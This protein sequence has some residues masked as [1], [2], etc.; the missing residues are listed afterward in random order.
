MKFMPTVRATKV[1]KAEPAVGPSESDGGE[2][3]RGRGRGRGERGRGRGRGRG[4]FGKQELTASGPFALGPA[5]R[6]NVRSGGGGFAPT[7]RAA[8]GGPGSGSAS[9]GGFSGSRVGGGGS[10]RASKVKSEGDGSGD[11]G[12]DAAFSDS[13]DDSEEADNANWGQG[14]SPLQMRPQP[15][16]KVKE[17][18]RRE[19]VKKERREREEKKVQ[20]K[21][22]PMEEDGDG[23]GSTPQTVSSS[24]PTLMELDE[25]VPASGITGE[26]GSGIQ[27]PGLE[28][29]AFERISSEKP[30]NPPL[31]FFQLPKLLPR[32]DPNAMDITPVSSS[33][34][35]SMKTE[36]DIKAD[37]SK[38]QPSSGAGSAKAA[39]PTILSQS[40]R[41]GTLRVHRS[42]RVTMDLGGAPFVVY[43]GSR[44]GF[45][46]QVSLIQVMDDHKGKVKQEVPRGWEKPGEGA[47]R[48]KL[49]VVGEV[50]S[51]GGRFVVAAAV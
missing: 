20:I 48:A 42:G 3:G 41:I 6:P 12:K 13:D 40:G 16:G 44:V 23:R 34:S 36:V 29:A 49:E 24:T 10:S 45:A 18:R 33:S 31:L 8:S 1:A 28:L 35:T 14:P 38:P 26:P 2:G 22:E 25:K 32:L 27:S 30:E 50:A 7:L 9:G 21:A 51:D 47:K 17:Q 15:L 11:E 5:A 39:V 37:P 43:P 4:E 19:K 46:E